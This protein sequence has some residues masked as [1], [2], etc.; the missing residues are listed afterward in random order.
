M[1]RRVQKEQ[2]S[3]RPSLV[4]KGFFLPIGQVSSFLLPEI[5]HAK[6]SL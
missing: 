5:I 4:T 2:W 6:S 1:S 3:H